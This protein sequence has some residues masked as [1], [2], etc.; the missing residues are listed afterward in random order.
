MKENTK[1][2]WALAEAAV[3]GN[4]DERTFASV[5]AVALQAGVRRSTAGRAVKSLCDVG[6]AHWDN[7]SGELVVCAPY[8]TVDVYK[9]TW[10]RD[11]NFVGYA[12]EN[13]VANEIR[14][15][16]AVWGGFRAAIHHLDGHIPASPYTLSAYVIDAHRLSLNKS[17]S[18]ETVDVYRWDTDLPG[19]EYMSVAQTITELFSTPG[20]ISG[21]FYLALYDKYVAEN[22]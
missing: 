3:S 6:G 13:D 9:T 21:D 7:G 4:L 19:G 10:T 15:G 5:D 18:N 11:A 16:R 17:L 1:V 22:R 12:A 2:L 8:R 20:W 14:S